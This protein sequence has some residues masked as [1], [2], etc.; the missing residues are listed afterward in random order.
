[1]HMGQN[2]VRGVMLLLICGSLLAGSGAV[3]A[4]S[5]DFHLVGLAQH[6]QT[7]RNIYL[8]AIYFDQHGPKPA[9]MV[10]ASG[11]KLMEYRV[12]ARRTSI[13]SLLGGML[14]QSEVATG[15]APDAATTEFA[16]AILSTV[17][18][19]LYAG[20]SFEILLSEDDET[21]AYLNGHELARVDEGNVSDYLLMGW[22]GERG[23]S[24]V[25]RESM[26]GDEIDASL[27]SDLETVSFSTQRAAEIAGWI[28]APQPGEQADT[29]AAT[30]TSA[31]PVGSLLPG[32]EPEPEQEP[33]P[34]PEPE[35]EQLAEIAVLSQRVTGKAVYATPQM[36]S[37]A[38]LEP[39]LE[40]PATSQPPIDQLQ[41]PALPG[42]DQENIQVAALTPTADLL[43]STGENSIQALDITEYS[44]R[45]TEFHG[46]LVAMVYRKIRYPK[47][48][49]RRGLEGRL[50]LDVTLLEDGKLVAINVVQPSG[51]SILD[52][53]A[54]KAAEKALAAGQLQDIDPVAVAEFSS[55]QGG[56]I[57][58]PVPVNF[59]LQD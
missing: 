7:G 16:N 27:L 54:I 53:A 24:T 46:Q 14:L 58:V 59:M 3:Q 28:D 32:P 39:A 50:E 42:Q 21:F 31:E 44:E 33:E 6:Q 8:G 47:R 23:P 35:P 51:H 29:V 26:L 9:D 17:K 4:T 45:L 37:T 56:N 36:E 12:I 48:A 40:L 22:V 52:N 49:V 10:A 11:P 20:D 57:V 15:A 43:Q 13:R 34:E 2:L 5:S 38:T 55:G 30:T 18:G 19:S 41:D 25:F 1:M